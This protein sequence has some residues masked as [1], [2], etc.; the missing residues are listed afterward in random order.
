MGRQP[1]QV[2]CAVRRANPGLLVRGQ[3]PGETAHFL[4]VLGPRKHIPIISFGM[5]DQLAQPVRG[6]LAELQCGHAHADRFALVAF[7]AVL[8]ERAGRLGTDFRWEEADDKRVNQGGREFQ[9]EPTLRSKK[10]LARQPRLALVPLPVALLED[11][12]VQ[13]P[14]RAL[15]DGHVEAAKIVRR[16][17]HAH[18]PE[19]PGK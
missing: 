7:R 18:R 6:P 14:I 17:R 12:Q 4:R 19:R 13:I 9:R 5:G 3:P 10:E 8:G 11:A 15:L 2:L 1:S 16:Q